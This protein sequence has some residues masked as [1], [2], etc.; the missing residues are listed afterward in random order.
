MPVNGEP[1]EL[2]PDAV[3]RKYAAR[4]GNNL[5]L[6]RALIPRSESSSLTDAADVKDLEYESDYNDDLI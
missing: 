1:P 5:E 4:G 6:V 2:T 3:G